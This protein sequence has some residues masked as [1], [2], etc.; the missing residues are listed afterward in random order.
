MAHAAGSQGPRHQDTRLTIGSQASPTLPHSLRSC[1][2][3]GERRGA[4]CFGSLSCRAPEAA[5]GSLGSLV[6]QPRQKQVSW[7][8]PHLDR[9]AC[10][11]CSHTLGCAH[12]LSLAPQELQEDPASTRAAQ[13][14]GAPV[15]QCQAWGLPVRLCWNTSGPSSDL[16]LQPKLSGLL[17]GTHHWLRQETWPSA[18][19]PS[20]R[21]TLHWDQG[22]L[23][24]L[25]GRLRTTFA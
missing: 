8:D 7:L 3:Q 23:W 24:D 16:Q 13:H 19:W 18:H 4:V 6:P 10:S 20:T 1:C 12:E 14:P 21:P 17:P 5:Q 2:V 11:T 9:A 15:A 25:W 22:G